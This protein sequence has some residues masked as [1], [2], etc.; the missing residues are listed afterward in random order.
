M[1]TGKA[2]AQGSHASVRAY[3]IAPIGVIKDWNETGSTKIV[4]ACKTE[5]ALIRLYEK[6]KEEKLPCALILDEGRTEFTEPT[7]TCCAI[8]PA[9]NEEIDEI[10]ARLRLY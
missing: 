6:A 9:E 7:L 8:G 1:S 5:G 4:L 2:V 3:S 10:T